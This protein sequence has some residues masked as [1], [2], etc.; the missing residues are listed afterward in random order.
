MTRLEINKPV[1]RETAAQERA[2]PLV[3]ALH[4]R[5]L[6]MRLKGTRQAF[7]VDYETVLDL[8]RKLAW[9][10]NGGR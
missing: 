5:Y 3:V 10:R 8:A 6:E 2:T 9:R 4:P 7:T 1:V